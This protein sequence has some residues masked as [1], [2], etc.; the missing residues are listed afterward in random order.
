MDNAFYQLL[1][2][3]DFDDNGML[4]VNFNTTDL[5]IGFITIRDIPYMWGPTPVEVHS[6]Q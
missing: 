4:Y 1:Y 6:W 3:L 2:K 5:D